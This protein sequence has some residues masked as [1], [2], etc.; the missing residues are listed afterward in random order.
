M[1][2]VYIRKLYSFTFLNPMKT[3]QKKKIG[4]ISRHLVWNLY[5]AKVY[6]CCHLNLLMSVDDSLLY[7]TTSGSLVIQFC[8][9]FYLFVFYRFLR[10]K[11]D[12]TSFLTFFCK[13]MQ[14]I[15]SMKFSFT[16]ILMSVKF[17]NFSHF[18]FSVFRFVFFVSLYFRAEW[19]VFYFSNFAS[20][21]FP[22][23]TMKHICIN[24][25]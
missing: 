12:E 19:N 21:S 20:Q 13:N 18:P 4:S 9:E 22:L 24:K 2:N 11:K 15:N 8:T 17:Y 7:I 3:L 16:Q 1:Y 23:F 25:M 14:I 5:E 10:F 6:G